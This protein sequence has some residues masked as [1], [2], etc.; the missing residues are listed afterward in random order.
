MTSSTIGRSVSAMTRRERVRPPREHEVSSMACNVERLGQEI[1]PV[2]IMIDQLEIAQRV[3]A[4]EKRQL[5]ERREWL[6][7]RRVKSS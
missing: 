7:R 1:G 2:E 5:V 3:R 6:R 4:G